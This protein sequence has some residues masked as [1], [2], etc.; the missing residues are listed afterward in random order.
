MV[1]SSIRCSIKSYFYEFKQI[2]QVLAY[3]SC[4]L[5]SCISKIPLIHD[6]IF[7]FCVACPWYERRIWI[8]VSTGVV[9][10]LSQKRLTQGDHSN[11]QVYTCINKKKT[12]G[13]EGLFQQ[14]TRKAGNAF[15][16]LKCHIQEIVGSFVKIC[17]NSLDSNLF[18]GSNLRQNSAKSLFRGCFLDYN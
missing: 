8:T 18:M 6:F 16:G 11:M 7:H 5:H 14:R 4:F 9:Y 3:G 12:Q 2:Y 13:K 1:Y 17:S 15:R 10:C